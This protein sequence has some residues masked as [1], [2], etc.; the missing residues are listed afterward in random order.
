MSVELLTIFRKQ[1]FQ[2]TNQIKK[3]VSC[4]K[5]ELTILYEKDCSGFFLS[6][7]DYSNIICMHKALAGVCTCLSTKLPSY[8]T[9]PLVCSSGLTKIRSK[10]WFSLQVPRVCTWF[11]WSAFS[12]YAS[13]TWNCLQSILNMNSSACFNGLFLYLVIVSMYSISF[14]RHHCK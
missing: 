13:T 11:D 6:L 7:F 3:L 8:H 10:D 9:S 1:T 2:S 12:F 4:Y 5:I 14:T